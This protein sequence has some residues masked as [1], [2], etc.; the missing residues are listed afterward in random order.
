MSYTRRHK[1]NGYQPR[2]DQTDD[3]DR[4]RD[5]QGRPDFRRGG[6]KKASCGY[7]GRKGKHKSL[8][9]RPAWGEKCGKCGKKSHFAKACKQKSNNSIA[10]TRVFRRVIRQ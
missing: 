1:Q 2:R 4:K 3:S 7:F 5:N 8:E 10:S 9:D 6:D